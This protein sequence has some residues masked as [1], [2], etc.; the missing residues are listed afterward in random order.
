MES[1]L[2]ELV[3]RHGA[4]RAPFL[5][6]GERQLTLDDVAQVGGA[7]LSAI[8][9]GDV[10]ALVGDFDA[11][12]IRTLLRLIGLGTVVVPLTVETRHDHDYFFDAAG[13]D[14]VVEGAVS[15]RLR[16]QRLDHPLLAEMRR[17]AVPGLVLFSSGTTGRPKAILHDFSRFLA[18][19][20]TPR[21]ALRTLNFLLFDHIGGLNTLLHTLFNRGLVV[22][23]SARTPQAVVDD[24]ERHAIELL[25]TTPTFLRMLL[26]SGLLEERALPA[27]KVVTYGT[28]R[29][30]QGT[31]DRLCALLPTVDFRQT[32][33]MSELGILRIRSRSRDSLWMEVGGEGVEWRV[34]DGVL[35]L[36]AEGRMLGYLNA[37]SPFDAD[38]WYDSK[39]RVEQEGQWLRI[40]GRS[41]E[42]ISVGGVKFLPGEV[43]RAAL[44][45]PEV[46]HAK[47]VGVDNPITGQHVEITCELKEGA[48][49]TRATL[50]QHFAAHLAESMRPH[51]IRIG[52]VAVGHRFKKA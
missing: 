28:E 50:R 17:R 35:Q 52:K 47:A 46:I 19:Y 37:P 15:R 16:A 29:M 42:T 23:P 48:T 4:V 14:W 26:M 34:V 10:V 32:Y 45:H 51:R 38:G 3:A 36:R 2:D 22:V 5:I 30:D 21:P 40:V 25:P 1:L 8:A 6:D 44:L 9:P 31:L 41:S 18:R 27:L 12:T 20:R 13:V 24:I 39:D 33:G 11:A 49:A 43:E 7:D